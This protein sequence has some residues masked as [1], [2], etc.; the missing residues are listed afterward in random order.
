MSIRDRIFGTPDQ[1]QAKQII[2]DVR[3]NTA[4]TREP[5]NKIGMAVVHAANTCYQSIKPMI[6]TSEE[7]TIAVADISIF[8]E[9]VF[10]FLHMVNRAAHP[11]FT[12]VQFKKLHEYF[13]ETVIP[14]SI[15]SF[16]GH[17]PEEIKANIRGEFFENLN[18]AEIEYSTAKALFP[19]DQPFLG[20]SLLS[21]LARTIAKCCGQPTNPEVMMSVIDSAMHAI[22]EA[23]FEELISVAAEVL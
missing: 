6:S 5:L 2:R 22:T 21:M 20:D 7:T 18:K 12:T 10:F 3:R 1:R 9:F 19:K 17:W 13:G 11:R 14:V 4:R 8:H 23:K 15:D 16:M